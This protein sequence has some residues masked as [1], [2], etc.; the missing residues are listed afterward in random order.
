MWPPYVF[1]TVHMAV[2]LLPKFEFSFLSV[3]PFPSDSNFTA[4]FGGDSACFCLPGAPF[5]AVMVLW[6][7]T[8]F[9]A[10]AEVALIEMTSLLG[11]AVKYKTQA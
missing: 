1:S 9:P 3:N 2:S 7:I 10:S 4:S 6:E 8:P 11:S 5:W